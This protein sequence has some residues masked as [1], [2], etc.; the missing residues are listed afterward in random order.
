MEMV[1]FEDEGPLARLYN[2]ESWPG[3]YSSFFPPHHFTSQS[4]PLPLC[5]QP[6]F[7][8][9]PCLC[10][11]S[12]TS[13]QTSSLGYSARSHQDGAFTLFYTQLPLASPTSNPPFKQ[14]LRLLRLRLFHQH[15]VAI[16]SPLLRLRPP[17]RGNVLLSRL[18][19]RK[20]SCC[21]SGSL[22]GCQQKVSCCIGCGPRVSCC[23]GCGPRVSCCRTGRL[24]GRPQQSLAGPDPGT[25]DPRGA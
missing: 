15:T 23:S 18:R 4:L 22:G 10:A 24:G 21:R 12:F 6:F 19:R 14:Q 9:E 2:A 7:S 11:S 8:S 16:S 13:S 17:P 20:V 25:E 1:K 3:F 5:Q